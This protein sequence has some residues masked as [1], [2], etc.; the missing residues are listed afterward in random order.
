LAPNENLYD[1]II[2]FKGKEII[3]FKKKKLFGKL[4]SDSLSVA[5]TSSFND[6]SS[7]PGSGL[8]SKSLPRNHNQKK[9]SL[10][11]QRRAAKVANMLGV[12]E[13]KNEVS[14]DNPEIKT[15]LKMLHQMNDYNR[16]SS[17]DMEAMNSKVIKEGWLVKEET[18]RAART[19]WCLV[20]DTTFYAY[21]KSGLTDEQAVLKLDLHQY[22]ARRSSKN[23]QSFEFIKR[24]DTYASYFF[25]A[26]SVK[27]CKDWVS[28]VETALKKE[29]EQQVIVHKVTT[30][31]KGKE[32]PKP[33]EEVSMNDFNIHK[34]LGRGKFGK[35]TF[36]CPKLKV[37]LASQKS[38]GKVFAIKCIKKSIISNKN[39]LVSTQNENKIL[40][41]VRNPFIVQLY[42]AFET[43]EY[44]NLVMEYINGGELFFHISHFGRFS[45]VR[46]R[47]Y[48]AQISCALECL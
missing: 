13:K 24:T 43:E 15:I 23:K 41:T 8:N 37:M 35:V 17:I 27:A 21:N 48:A 30:E 47:F 38:S 32:E 33:K 34:V 19:L 40:R 44:L 22:I 36:K 10:A 42:F 25:N 28:A 4:S 7:P 1:L 26:D 18:L 11:A 2:S 39:I 9:V 31:E 5:T 20:Q 12:S 45:E 14:V 3:V 6:E 29:D 16:K 46:V